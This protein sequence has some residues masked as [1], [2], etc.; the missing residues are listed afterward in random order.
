VLLAGQRR[1]LGYV[2]SSAFGYSGIFSFIS[3]S[4]F[5][6]MGM[7]K[8][9]P[10]AYGYCFAAAVAGY[11]VGATLAGKLA[12]KVT[13]HHM[14]AGGGAIAL[15]GGILLIALALAGEDTVMAIVIPTTVY[16]F[17]V[18]M[19]MANSMAGA[20]GPYPRAAGAA[21]ALLGFTQM[22]TAALVGAAIGHAADGTQMPMVI[23]L[24]LS[25][26]AGPLGYW[27]LVRPWEKQEG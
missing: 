22:S 18:G 13:L 4:S 2:L 24:A 9:E 21:S 6:L 16:L 7:M 26:V 5:V 12:R 27:L 1:Y 8:L 15:L 19:V 3:G 20:I 17:G 10:H 23:A 14:I 11:I 25:A